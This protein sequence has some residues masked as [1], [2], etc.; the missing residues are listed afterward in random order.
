MQL[1]KKTFSSP[2]TTFFILVIAIASINAWQLVLPNFSYDNSFAIAAAKN[3]FG[4]K[5]YSLATVSAKDLSATYFEPLNKWPPGYSWLLVIIKVI[6]RVDWI[7]ASYI[8]NAIGA[9]LLVLAMRKILVLLNVQVWAIN[10]YM[11]FAGFVPYPFLSVWF[12]DLIAVAFFMWAIFFL[13]RI[14]VSEN[15][16][17]LN[18]IA[19][20]LLLAYCAWLKYL[21]YS[22]SFVPLLFL[23]FYSVRKKNP[24]I[25]KAVISAC[26]IL[27]V[28]IMYMLWFQQ[29]HS[30]SAVYINPTGKGFFPEHILSLAPIIPASLIDF[31]FYDM[32]LS[33]ILNMPYLK[34]IIFWQCVN[35]LLSLLMLTLAIRYIKKTGF[36]F[37]SK[38]SIYMY[39]GITTSVAIFFQLLYL[40]LTQKPYNDGYTK[41]WTYVQELRYYAVVFIFIQQG[42][43]FLMLYKQTLLG[44]SAK[45]FFA[46]VIMFTSVS[47]IH[48][49]YYLSKQILIKKEFGK[50]RK[51]ELIDFV[52][53]KTVD[54]LKK[55]GPD[56]VICSDSHELDNI[57]SL[58]GTPALYEW[59]SLNKAMHHSK[60]VT[61]LVILNSTSLDY[62]SNFFSLYKPVQFL[63]I[64]M[65]N[66]IGE[67][68]NFYTV[69]FF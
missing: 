68:E 45:F 6:T 34:V 65:P 46:L 37:T 27:S 43:L 61:L 8:L 18:A 60:P 26:F 3:I 48:G 58:S 49:F 42:I 11:L 35:V 36:H 57:G 22:I 53:V 13:M 28:C 64:D 63:K 30:G 25:I 41:F 14:I 51:S 44:K 12:S 69:K 19:A 67:T 54:S 4:G 59:A 55:Q 47:I 2:A 16:I 62:Y 10:A 32:Q 50:N 5:G 1:F 66:S 29:Q 23:L 7:I 20:A 21:Y 40:S 52:T 24:K 17:F 31:R 9:T 56:L 39:L 15:K 38:R 33:R